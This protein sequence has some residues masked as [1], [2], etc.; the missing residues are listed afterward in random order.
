[1]ELSRIVNCHGQNIDTIVAK[2]GRRM[3]IGPALINKAGPTGPS[4]VTPGQP[5]SR[6]I[7]CHKKGLGLKEDSTAGPRMYTE[8]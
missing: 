8:S 2:M 1:M 4:F 6:V 7:R 5:F 3:L